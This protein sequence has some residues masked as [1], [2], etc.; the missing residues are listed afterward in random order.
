MKRVKSE[1]PDKDIWVWT[2]YELHEL[3]EHQQQVLPYIDTLIDGKFEQDKADPSLD[4]RGS[5]NQII[6]T[7]T[8]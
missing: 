8:L 3:D 4:W 6:H 2:G 1:C 5:S 7:F